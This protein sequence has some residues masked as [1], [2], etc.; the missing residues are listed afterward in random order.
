MIIDNLRDTG[1]TTKSELM[2]WLKDKY[3]EGFFDLDSSLLELFKKDIV[4]QVSVKGLPS[5]LIVL[6]TDI[7]MLRVPS[8]NLFKDPSG[9][10]LPTQFVKEY[11]NDVKEFFQTYRPTAEDNVK[12][13]ETLANPEVFETFRLLRT[14]IVTRQDLE[15]LRA[16][17]VADIYGVLKLLWDSKMIKVFRDENNNEYYALLTDFYIDLLF[18]KYILRAIKIAYE[19][20]SMA[21]KALIEYLNVLE[22]AYYIVKKQDKLTE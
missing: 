4:K 7:F 9:S 6:T 2:I 14:A 16:K 18:P 15:K 13:I 11:I 3:V 19:Q 1:V 8:I 17:G 5:S 20:K 22:N 12:I 21:D 10:G